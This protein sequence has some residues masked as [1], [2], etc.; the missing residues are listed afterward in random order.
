VVADIAALTALVAAETSR[1]EAVETALGK[2]Q[3][4]P[5]SK[6]ANYSAVSGDYI[7]ATATLTVTTPAVS[8]GAVFG[9]VANYA[10]S[11]GSPVTITA[12][13][14]FLIGPGIPS[15][16]SSIILGTRN[17]NVIFV[18][19]GTDWYLTEG[20]QDSGWIQPTY[21]GAWNGTVKIRLVGNRVTIKGSFDVLDSSGT[22]AFNL[23]TGMIPP[24]TMYFPLSTFGT[25]YIAY[26]A[27]GGGGAGVVYAVGA[28]DAMLDGITYLIDE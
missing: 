6:L 22:T 15:S 12:S 8:S 5:I 26:V 27:V 4:T 11:N 28:N 9:V 18:S 21:L 24:A 19:D 16:T 25:T 13:S 1:A 17:A 20:A 2:K 7:N 23:P 3:L 14:G 10:A